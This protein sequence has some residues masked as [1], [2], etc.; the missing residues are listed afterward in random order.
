MP[1]LPSA[2]TVLLLCSFA[3]LGAQQ[4]TTV[5]TEAFPGPNLAARLLAADAALG[6]RPGTLTVN[7]PGT[8]EA[9]FTLHAGHSLLLR[10]P[11]TW[12]ASVTLAGGNSITCEGGG[13]AQ[14]KAAMPAF[15]FPEGGAL[16][17]AKNVSGI[18]VR[19]CTVRSDQTSMLL[20]GNNVSDVT[21]EGN[22][23]SGLSL[24]VVSEG[25]STGLHFTGN[26][27]TFPADRHSDIAAISLYAARGVTAASNHFTRTLHGIHWWGGD[28]GAPG[29][30]LDQVTGTGEMR[31]TGNTCAEVGSCIWGSMGY[32]I[33][34]TGNTATGCGDVCFDTEGGRD[35]EFSGNTASGC[36]NGCGAIFFFT[37]NT[38]FARNHF[39]G[40]TGG[41]LIFIK[42]ASQDPLHHAGVVISGNT[43]DCGV[44]LCRAVYAEAASGIVF[45]NNDVSNGTFS[46]VNYARSVTISGNRF[47]F[48]AP[49]PGGSPAI[50]APAL[51]GGTTL[52]VRDNTIIS[53]VA[54]APGTACIAA[55]WSDF[56]ATDLHIFAG[57][58][59]GGT[60][61]FP[62]GIVTT[63][64]G[65]NPGPRAFWILAGNTSAM[66]PAVHHAVTQNEVYGELPSCPGNACRPDPTIARAQ[67]PACS[68]ANFG[69]LTAPPHGW[70][71][72]VCANDTTG[73]F[74]WIPLPATR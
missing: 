22:T 7:A 44:T 41:G 25:L 50:A 49:L 53:E 46:P 37:R 43:L 27:V 23:L 56:N 15:H 40:P 61:P 54:Q 64:D 51:V 42:N 12:S 67:T 5:A 58:R 6:S 3:P 36:A 1:R 73:R 31:F 24:A 32:S 17:L 72:S 9:A 21:F 74:L 70:S 8:L 34:I 13:A 66:Q 45:D 63:T 39:T 10:A 52:L 26:S 71:T 14:I 2:A 69:Q 19:G 20:A 62:L 11:I 65:K 55:G 47:R 16:L 30:N 68:A 38:V 33:A 35:T 48:T 60:H 57:N 4:P 59:C 28:S 29:A 18:T